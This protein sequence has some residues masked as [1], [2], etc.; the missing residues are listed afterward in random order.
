MVHPGQYGGQEAV[1]WTAPVAGDADVDVTIDIAPDCKDG[2]LSD[3]VDFTLQDDA[4]LVLWSGTAVSPDQLY[5]FHKVLPMAAGASLTFSTDA[6]DNNWCDWSTLTFH[7]N[8]G[9]TTYD[10]GGDFLPGVQGE[11]G[12]HFIRRELDGAEVPL[13]YRKNAQ[14][15]MGWGTTDL[16]G[17]VLPWPRDRDGDGV[18]DDFDPYPNVGPQQV[19]LGAAAAGGLGLLVFLILGWRNRALRARNEELDRIVDARTK[20]LAASVNALARQG[21]ELLHKTEELQDHRSRLLAQ[22]EHLESLDDLRSRAVVNMQHELRTPVSLVLGPLET[23]A[24]TGEL[25]PDLERARRNAARLHQLVEQ[26]FDASRLNAGALPLLARRGDLARFVSEVAGRFRDDAAQR[27]LTYTIE[28]AE[29]CATWFDP[30]LIDKV[31]VNLIANALKFTPRG[32]SVRVEVTAEGRV[33]V[34]DSGPGVPVS[35]RERVFARLY[36]VERGDARPHQGA[37]IGLALVRELVELHGGEVGVGDAEEGGARFW[38]TLQRGVGHLALGDIQ[39]GGSEGE[40]SSEWSGQEGGPTVLIVEDEPDMRE[41]LCELLAPTY[42][43]RAARDGREGLDLA[44]AEPPAVIVSDV[45]MPRMTGLA[46]CE[47]LGD[48]RPPVVLVSAKTSAE[49]QSEGLRVADAY[50]TKPFAVRE[51]LET[52]QRLVPTKDDAVESAAEREWM[53][54]LRGAL[55]DRLDDQRFG[56][57]ALAKAV[58]MSRRNL[59][60][61]LSARTGLAIRD[62]MREQRLRAGEE[63]LREGRF[64]TVSEV[65]AAV[66]LSRSYFTRAY[67]AWTG[68]APK[69][70]LNVGRG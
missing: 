70:D 49:A 51:L 16:N 36:Q 21:Q 40:F 69:E 22:T 60:R 10:V 30:D 67:T 7:V 37:G 14:G 1:V 35:E 43:I 56:V 44:R 53:E 31:V 5:R 24:E 59:A 17:G 55:A 15:L 25:P 45:M 4:G 64:G 65:A 11:R 54:R 46:M 8:L 57:E 28:A 47:A 20:E 23:R 42:R 33:T 34:S 19:L 3:G 39:R 52:V 48:D 61:Q 58:G 9:G 66:G 2:Y 41:Y 63:M 6:R 50:I 38:F 27:G 13:V 32:G 29:P 68:R 18:D 26:L 62:W 12:W